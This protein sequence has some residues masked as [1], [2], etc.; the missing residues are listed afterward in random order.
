MSQ[1]ATLLAQR[2]ENFSDEVIAFVEQLSKDDWTTVC[3][4]EQWSVGVT[5]YHVGAGHLAIFDMA[6]MIITGKELPQLDMQQIFAMANQQ[7][8]ENA[9]CT[10]TET[11]ERLRQNKAGPRRGR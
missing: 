6:E 1:R 2:V 5:A 7:A 4:A 11:L 3:D 8:Q 10:Q 9:A